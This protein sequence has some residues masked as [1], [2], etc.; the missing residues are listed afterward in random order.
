[1]NIGA[2]FVGYNWIPILFL[3]AGIVF[4]VIEMLQPGFG[5]PGIIGIVLLLLG[6]VLY[7]RSLLEALIMIIILLAILG[8]ALT[9]ILQS[10]SKGRLARS[11]VLNDTLDNNVSYPAI[12]DMSYFLGSEG[13]TITPLRPSGVADFSG[14]KLDVVS[15]GEYIPKNTT[16]IIT[17]IEGN[18][19]IVR[20]KPK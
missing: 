3:I 9:L 15:D 5:A 2:L 12:D 1:V 11:L 20:Q 4:I 18:R 17:K 10:A 19:I 14:V 16:V 8:V 7:A 13:E 6:I